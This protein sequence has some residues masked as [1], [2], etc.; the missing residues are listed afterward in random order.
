MFSIK[1]MEHQKNKKRKTKGFDIRWSEVRFL[2]GTQ[3]FFFVPRSWQ[4]EKHLSLKTSL[5]FHN[6]S[7]SRL[8]SKPRLRALD[9]A[10]Q[11]RI[12]TIL[13]WLTQLGKKNSL[14]FFPLEFHHV[15]YLITRNRKNFTHIK[16]QHDRMFWWQLTVFSE[17]FSVVHP[18]RTYW[19]WAVH[20]PG[21]PHCMP[22][23][24]ASHYHSRP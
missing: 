24:Q 5:L 11:G 2:M 21:L 15:I 22:L 17:P 20:H 16:R 8:T 4:N 23:F 12:Q 19:A 6:I 14:L 13:R 18:I 1:V 7:P 10:F 3:N 9:P